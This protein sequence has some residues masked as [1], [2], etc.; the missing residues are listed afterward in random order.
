LAFGRDDAGRE[1]R[2][3][4]NQF[5]AS[6]NH[7]M[8][9]LPHPD[10]Q[11]YHGGEYSSRVNGASADFERPAAFDWSAAHRRIP[12]LGLSGQQEG[13]GGGCDGCEPAKPL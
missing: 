10:R 13:H 9:D 11:G 3:P 7:R 12:R 8:T 6:R 4:L 5:L 1:D 2:E